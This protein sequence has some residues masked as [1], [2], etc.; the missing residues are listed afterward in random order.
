MLCRVERHRAG[1]DAGRRRAEDDVEEPLPL[2]QEKAINA[3]E[4]VHHDA[5]EEVTH[6]TVDDVAAEEPEPRSTVYTD[7]TPTLLRRQAR[8]RRV[9]E[10]HADTCKSMSPF[11]SSTPHVSFGARRAGTSPSGTTPPLGPRGCGDRH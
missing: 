7:A 6:A 11:W 5:L 10:R 9:Q 2:V 8:R 1:R 3:P 4:A